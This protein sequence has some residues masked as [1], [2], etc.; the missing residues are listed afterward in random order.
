MKN[1]IEHIDKL[2]EFGK[3]SNLNTEN[4]ISDLKKALIGI[5]NAYVNLEFEFDEKDYPEEPDFDYKEIRQNLSKNFPEFGLYHV[6]H[7]CHIIDKDADLVIGDALD[8]LT[9]IIKDL[10]T[11]KWKYENTS[12]DDARWEFDFSM[13]NHSEMHL[14][15][16]LKYL[17]DRFS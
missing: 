2:I 15:S 12:I 14:V 4:K 10:L 1:L 8:D 17:K 3:N 11:V 9:D 6:A 7:D 16:F 13:K 5:Y